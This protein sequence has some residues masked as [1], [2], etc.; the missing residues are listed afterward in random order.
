MTISDLATRID[1]HLKRNYGD[2]AYAIQS[3]SGI[4]VRVAHS[5]ADWGRMEH[6]L[7]LSEAERY[8]AWLDAGGVGRHWDM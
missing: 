6:R 2:D 3:M 7:T 1:A 5:A 8:P 4:M